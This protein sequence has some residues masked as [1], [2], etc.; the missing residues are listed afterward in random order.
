MAN[1]DKKTPATKKWTKVFVWVMLVSMLG[2]AF[3]SALAI[4]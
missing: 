4:L 1:K 2:S 3:I